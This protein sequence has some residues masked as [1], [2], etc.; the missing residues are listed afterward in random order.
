[1][2]SFGNPHSLNRHCDLGVLPGIGLSEAFGINDAG[3][4]VGVEYSAAGTHGYATEWSGGSVI[5]ELGLLP[6]TR[7]S[8]AFG[9]N[10]AGQ[11][12]GVSEFPTPVPE[13]STWAMMLAGFAGLGL[14]GYRHAKAGYPTL[15]LAQASVLA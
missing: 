4:V 7:A 5:T 14:A 3:Q 10:D 6:G 9:I 8:D 2:L 1:M 12:V 15:A 13:P 11:A